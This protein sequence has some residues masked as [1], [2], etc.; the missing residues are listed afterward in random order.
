MLETLGV[1]KNRA[2]GGAFPKGCC[3]DCE[4]DFEE[5]TLI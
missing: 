1:A 2:A 5:C 3:D 4:E